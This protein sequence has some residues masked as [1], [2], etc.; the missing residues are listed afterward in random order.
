M[1]TE[2]H[3]RDHH[4]PPGMER[5]V[6]VTLREEDIEALETEADN[7]GLSRA[8][9]IRQ[10]IEE[11]LSGPGAGPDQGPGQAP[12]L[13]KALQEAQGD[14]EVLMT[15]VEDL[16]KALSEKNRDLEW[17]RGQLQAV[18]ATLTEAV[19]KV[20]DPRPALTTEAGPKRSWW[21]WVTGQKEE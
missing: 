13:T 20:P 19:K 14:R 12:A 11:H 18:M 15:R 5:V 2:G 17:T 21:E 10:I 3:M 4:Q 1:Q 16:E 8:T 9:L 7:K 6:K